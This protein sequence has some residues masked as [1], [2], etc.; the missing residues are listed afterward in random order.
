MR[1]TRAMRN[2]SG[3]EARIELIRERVARLVPAIPVEIVQ[4]IGDDTAVVRLGDQLILFTVDMLVEGVHFRLDW[5]DAYR[6]GWKALAVNLS[7]IGAMGGQPVLALLSLAMPE[8]MGAN[9]ILSYEERGQRGSP[10]PFSGEKGQGV[11]GFSNLTPPSPLSA[12]REGGVASSG[13]PSPFTERGSGGEVNSENLTPPAPLSASREGGEP[14]APS[15]FTERGSGGE[16]NS[17]NLSPLSPLS[18]SREGGVASS[19]S[20]SP[21]TERGSG[22]EVNQETPSPTLPLNA[23]GGSALLPSPEASGEGLGVR[24]TE[25][26]TQKETENELAWLHAFANGLH[27]CASAYQTVIVGGDTNRSDK[28]VIDVMVMGLLEGEPVLRSGAQVGDWILVT[29][30]LGGSRAGLMRLMRGETNDEQA[31]TAHLMPIPRVREG[32]LLRQVGVHAMMDI[33]DGLAED[34]PRLLRAS[35]VGAVVFPHRIP[36]HLSAQR[37]AHQ[38]SEDPAQFALQGGED[39]ELLVCADPETAQKLLLQ[40]PTET[41][42]LLTWIGVI[43]PGDALWLEDEGGTRTPLTLRG[44][45]HF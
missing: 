36:V 15:P 30:T 10:S 3:E 43:E 13:S 18:A 2:R 27:D 22:G 25:T 11:E 28:I 29:G 35:G 17:E 14:S 23:G 8:R 24:A 31:L 38:A 7:D 12:S 42:T 26:P 40:L 19:G 16:V 1:Y 32:Q 37:Y 5:T 44:W 41:G 34:L 6:L 9:L 20:P 21:F 39:Y 33:S 4:G 45:S